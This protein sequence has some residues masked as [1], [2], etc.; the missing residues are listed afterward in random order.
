MP[1]SIAVHEVTGKYVINSKECII[2]SKAVNYNSQW[3]IRERLQEGGAGMFV[4]D[5][6]NIR[7]RRG[8]EEVV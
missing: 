5:G 6:E 7:G 4:G 1:N 2:S 3:N 8:G